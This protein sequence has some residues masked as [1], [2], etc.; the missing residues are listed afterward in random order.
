MQ[1]LNLFN[2]PPAAAA[3]IWTA[4]DQTQQ[5]AVV[6]KLAELIAKTVAPADQET[7]NE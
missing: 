6:T 5:A 2:P 7:N 4:L 1:Q 3:P